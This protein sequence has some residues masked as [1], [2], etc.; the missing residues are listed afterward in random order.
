M[1]ITY[2][3]GSNSQRLGLLIYASDL[4]IV[5]WLFI[6]F[7]LMQK[8]RTK[9]KIKKNISPHPAWPTLPGQYFQ[10]CALFGLAHKRLCIFLIEGFL[11][12]EKRHSRFG[13][14]VLSLSK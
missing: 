5:G 4:C 1:Y 9:E 6:S 11:L 2:N 13:C 10:A 3:L 8:K 12:V 7:A 14:V